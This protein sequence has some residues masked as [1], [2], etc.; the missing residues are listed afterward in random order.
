VEGLPGHPPPTRRPRRH[1]GLSRGDTTSVLTIVRRFVGGLTLT[2]ALTGC[3]EP[4]GQSSSIP[5]RSPVPSV[6]AS[7]AELVPS[8]E[9]STTDATALEAALP[10][11]LDGVEL[12]TFAVG[13]DIL[14]RLAIKF[15]VTPDE[16]ETAF[17][18]EHGARFLQMYAI[19]L[20]GKTADELAEGWSL[21]AY[22]PEV[23]DV[24]IAGETI[25]GAPITVVD[26]PST[27]SR[28]GTFYLDRRGDTLIVVQTFEFADA[29]EA[30]ASI[31]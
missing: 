4:P 24:A 6:A 23:D 25:D 12:H 17:A 11:E 18:S 21:V 26:S 8:T 14:A 19:R 31:H 10:R 2:V 27:R 16:L 30:L 15:G 29:V 13:E 5:S 20:S 9:P 1:R 7:A 28:L 3:A 22:P